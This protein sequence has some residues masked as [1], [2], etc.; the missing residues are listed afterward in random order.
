MYFRSRDKVRTKDQ[1]QPPSGSSSLN[2]SRLGKTPPGG[3]PPGIGKPLSRHTMCKPSCWAVHCTSNQPCSDF[4]CACL[5]MLF[6]TSATTISAHE[7]S[8]CGSP[9][10]SNT[11]LSCFNAWRTSSKVA[12]V[13]ERWWNPFSTD[14]GRFLAV[15]FTCAPHRPR[16]L[17]LHVWQRSY[18]CGSVERPWQRS[19]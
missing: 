18:P 4:F 13:G 14:F 17:R 10:S 11:D 2:R 5:T 16:L 19:E 3:A 9:A 7:I 6:N 12:W 15:D 8:S 1:P